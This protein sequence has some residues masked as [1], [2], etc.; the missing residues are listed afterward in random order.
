MASRSWRR[1]IWKLSYLRSGDD[2]DRE[3]GGRG[4]DRVRV[5]NGRA[6]AHGDRDRGHYDGGHYGR[7]HVNARAHGRG[8]ASGDGDDHLRH[9]P[10]CLA[11]LLSLSSTSSHHASSPKPIQE[12]K[13]LR[14]VF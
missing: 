14:Y 13:D 1:D 12:A 11:L 8:R 10:C 6:N 7:G 3:V 4:C 9:L 5:L 2:G